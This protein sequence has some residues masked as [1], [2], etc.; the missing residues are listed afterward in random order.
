MTFLR[1]IVG[2]FL[3]LILL[4]FLMENAHIYTQFSFFGT[5]YDMVP[6]WSII[7]VSFVL[8][9]AAASLVAFVE[10]IRAKYIIH[11][12]ER[13]IKRLEEEMDDLRQFVMEEEEEK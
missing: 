3:V 9:F 4:Y 10:I 1:F 6:V 2:F 5:R 7:F 12:K 8:G 13:M 11:K